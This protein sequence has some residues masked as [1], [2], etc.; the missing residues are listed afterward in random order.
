[1]VQRLEARRRLDDA[2]WLAARSWGALP[3]HGSMR[4]RAEFIEEL[5][6]T[7]EAQKP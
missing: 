1:M 4:Q 7:V 3:P 2:G 6:D 5:A